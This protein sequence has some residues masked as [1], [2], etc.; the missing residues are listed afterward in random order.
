MKRSHRAALT[1][2]KRQAATVLE[3]VATEH[4]TLRQQCHLLSATYTDLQGGFEALSHRHANCEATERSLRHEIAQLER[5]WYVR[6]F[7]IGDAS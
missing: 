4:E 3:S 7:G 2:V 1:A 6:L 5:P